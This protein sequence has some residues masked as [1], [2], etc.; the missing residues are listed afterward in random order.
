MTTTM[1]QD[2][3]DGRWNKLSLAEQ[4]GN[5]GSEVSRVIRAKNMHNEERKNRALDRAL[6]LMDL[7]IRDPKHRMRLK[8]LCR[9]REVMVDAFFGCN[10]YQ[11]DDAVLDRYFTYFAL[12]ARNKERLSMSW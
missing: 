12:A 11:S 4:L 1:H 3:A 7:T 2:L 6:E 10:E 9:A 5:V 8:E